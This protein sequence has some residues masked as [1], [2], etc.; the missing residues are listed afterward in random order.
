ML[1]SAHLAAGAMW[2]GAAPAVLLVMRDRAVADTE[3]VEVV[4]RFSRLAGVVLLVVG[5]AGAALTWNLSDGL[6]G[7]LTPWTLLLAAKVACVGFAALLGAWGRRHLGHDPRRGRLARLFALDA[8]L[9]VV[10]TLLSASLTLSG[11]HAG[12]ATHA[13]ATGARC[14]TTVGDDA[15]SLIALPGSAGTSEL[16][17]SGVR[18]DVQDVTLAFR[19]ELT[20]GGAL[21][22]SATPV[23]QG[24]RASGALPLAGDW[25]ATIAVRVDDFTLER[26]TCRLEIGP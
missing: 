16:L 7:G 8:S 22:M 13:M 21:T 9:L 6:S 12:H 4:R 18:A 10:I 24:W 17:V 2:L 3:A 25:E 14:S 23:E 5:G 19:H 15:V 11:P 26:G 1:L 20:R